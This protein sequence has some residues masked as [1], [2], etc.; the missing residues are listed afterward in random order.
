MRVRLQEPAA[1]PEDSFQ[2]STLNVLESHSGGGDWGGSW[3]WV[4]IKPAGDHRFWSLVP[5]T[6]VPFRVPIFDPQPVE[7]R[8]PCGLTGNRF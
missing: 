5:F 3:V 1:G 6:R 2:N 7:S 8:V 4:K